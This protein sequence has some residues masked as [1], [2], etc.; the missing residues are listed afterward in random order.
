MLIFGERFGSTM[1]QEVA[2][3]GDEAYGTGTWKILMA[4][5]G[6]DM[7]F[8]RWGLRLIAVMTLFLAVPWTTV[9]YYNAW[10]QKVSIDGKSLKFTGDAGGFFMVWLKTLALST[11]TLTL[12]WWLRGRKNKARWV[13]SNLSWA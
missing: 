6:I 13:D 7:F 4:E 11:I 12:Y 8:L 10:S 5:A 9:M 2:I 3:A 1:N